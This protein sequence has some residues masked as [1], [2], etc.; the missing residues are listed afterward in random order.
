M[1]QL[2]DLK[3]GFCRKLDTNGIIFEEFFHEINKIYVPA[4][5]TPKTKKAEKFRLLE[6]RKFLPDIIN[7]L[8]FNLQSVTRD[9]SDIPLSVVNIYRSSK[10]ILP[11]VISS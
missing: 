7:S 8:I 4:K 3:N 10:R 11:L 5:N 2:L 1:L 6:F 9:K